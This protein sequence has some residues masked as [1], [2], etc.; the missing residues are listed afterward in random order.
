MTRPAPSTQVPNSGGS[1]LATIQDS[2]GMGLDI[3]QVTPILTFSSADRLLVAVDQT[4]VLRLQRMHRHIFQARDLG[5]ARV[6]RWLFIDTFSRPVLA[7]P[8]RAG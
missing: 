3:D 2:L 5:K 7:S 6:N 1:H 4:P 8:L